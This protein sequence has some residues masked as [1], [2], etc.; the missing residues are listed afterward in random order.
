M[1]YIWPQLAFVN[2]GDDDGDADDGDDDI[3]GH[4]HLIQS[5]GLPLRQDALW[6]ATALASPHLSTTSL[7]VIIMVV[8]VMVI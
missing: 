7:R 3:D 2:D 5:A 1:P 8:M 6:I 4:E